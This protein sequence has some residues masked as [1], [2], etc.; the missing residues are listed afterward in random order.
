MKAHTNFTFDERND[1]P[2]NPGAQF[3]IT[4]QDPEHMATWEKNTARP[5]VTDA[6]VAIRETIEARIK[7]L[8]KEL[9]GWKS[10]LENM[11]GLYATQTPPGEHIRKYRDA[12]LKQITKSLETGK[13]S[14]GRYGSLEVQAGY[15]SRAK[16]FVFNIPEYANINF[17]FLDEDVAALQEIASLAAGV[18]QLPYWNGPG[19]FTLSIDAAM[20]KVEVTVA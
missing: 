18:P 4:S 3:R 5:S 17:A 19:L 10:Q 15:G 14:F 7:K 6:K 11:D 2:A 16:L 8:N 1:H 13:S 9:E 20:A 12:I